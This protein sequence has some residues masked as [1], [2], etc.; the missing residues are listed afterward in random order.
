MCGDRV[1]E[2]AE[3]NEKLRQRR[4]LPVVW[5]QKRFCRQ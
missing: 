1:P 4:R 2:A 3:E 5:W